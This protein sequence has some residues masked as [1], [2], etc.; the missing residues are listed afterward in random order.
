VHP[1]QFCCAARLALTPQAV[2]LAGRASPIDDDSALQPEAVLIVVKGA[3]YF[4]AVIAKPG[5]KVFG[6]DRAQGKF[7]AQLNVEPPTYR[8][9]ESALGAAA[10]TECVSAIA[11]V[12]LA[13]ETDAH[14][15]E[16]QL[17]KWLERALAS[18]R[19]PRSKQKGKTIPVYVAAYGGGDC[20]AKV[21]AATQI[22]RY[23]DQT[24]EVISERAPATSTIK[25]LAYAGAPRGS[26]R[27][28]GADVHERWRCFDFRKILSQ[29]H[30][31]RE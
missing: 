6:L 16:V 13:G 1:R 31:G 29:D 21:F 10:R 9:G 26:E 27:D 30:A 4:V 18:E 24:A 5:V 3:D 8:H 15:A 25:A 17:G 2:L 22:R 12:V 14:P 19:K 28:W 7:L 11:R 23:A 20:L